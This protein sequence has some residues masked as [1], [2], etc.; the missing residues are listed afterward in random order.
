MDEAPAASLTDALA[1]ATK[2][3]ANAPGL[4]ERQ[5]EEILKAVPT[6]P[7]AI[8]ILGMARRRKGDLVAAQAVL[9]PLARNQPRSA[10]THYE[11]GATLAGL[12]ETDRAIAALRHAVTLKRDMPEAWRALGD[13]LT[14]IGDVAGADAAYAE[15]IR[16]SVSDPALLAAADALCA[17]RLAVAERLLRDHLGA[18]PTDVAAMRLL[19]ETGTRLG[20][21]G[22]AEALLM[23]CLELAPGFDGAR[24]NLAVVLYRQQK[25]APAIPHLERLL[26]ADPREPAYRNLLAGCLGLVGE[27]DKA[28]EIYR[29]LLAEHPAQPRIWLSYGHAQRTAGRK[30]EAIGAYNRCLDL[31]PGLGEAYWSLAN[32]KTVPFSVEEEAAMR[33]QLARPGLG[34]DDSL[35]LHYALGK[36]LEDR[37]DCATAF[38]HYSSGAKLRSNELKY[39][40]AETTSRLRAARTLFTPRFF[41]ERANGGAPSVAPIFIVGLPRSGSTLIEQILASHSRVEG[42]ME[43]PDIPEMARVLRGPGR[44]SRGAAYPELLADL[45]RSTLTGLGEEFLARTTVH[46][47]LDRPRFI[48]KMPNNFHHIGLIHLI[49]PN[50]VVIDARRHPMGA[51]FSAFKQLFARGHAYSYDLGHVGRYYRDYVELMDHFDEVLP[52]RIHRVIYEDMVEDTERQVRKLLDHCGL[53]FESACLRFYENDRAVRTASSEQVRRPIFREGLEQ[54]RNFEPWLGPLKDALGPTLETWRGR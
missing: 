3:L 10:Q 16:A 11:L 8:L 5:A 43:L 33:T 6:D 50:A 24:Y 28:V 20:R 32:L 51:C 14:Q 38:A 47:K 1:H 45:D 46:R 41:A 48:D 49:L 19:A 52:G 29:R 13:Q 23:R 17:D 4:A 27:Y 25:A 15:H 34:G 31:A 30:D 39:D 44:E 40:A 22:D 35:H 12:G 37:G 2:L 18:N 9:E 7:R 54:W 36:A 21:Y 26:A 53:P 42:T